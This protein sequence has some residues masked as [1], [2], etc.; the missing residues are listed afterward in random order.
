MIF[1]G[2]DLPLTGEKIR[3][4]YRI[5]SASMSR[6]QPEKT[7]KIFRSRFQYYPRIESE[8]LASRVEGAHRARWVHV[9]PAGGGH[10][11]IAGL[12]MTSGIFRERQWRRDGTRLEN[13]VVAELQDPRTRPKR[14]WCRPLQTSACSVLLPSARCAPLHV[15][16]D[17]QTRFWDNIGI[18]F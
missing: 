2:Y 7:G 9:G 5:L 16:P 6:S 14:A 4:K 11:D 18:G 8:C 3:E 17:I 1:S 13:P 15:T 10:P 12:L